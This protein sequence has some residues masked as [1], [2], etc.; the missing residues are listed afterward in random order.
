M[1]KEDIKINSIILIIVLKKA[2]QLQFFSQ[3]TSTKF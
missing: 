3:T 2:N 1:E